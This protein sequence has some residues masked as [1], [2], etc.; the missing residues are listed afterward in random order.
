MY[1]CIYVGMDGWMDG[2]IDKHLNDHHALI[3][4]STDKASLKVSEM[5][6][7]RQPQAVYVQE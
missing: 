6:Q 7:S 5:V 2:W 3:G 1:A 4:F